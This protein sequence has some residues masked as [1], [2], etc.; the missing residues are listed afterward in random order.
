MKLAYCRF[1]IFFKSELVFKGGNKMK[2]ILKLSLFLLVLSF[3]LVACGTKDITA[4]KASTKATAAIPDIYP[5]TAGQNINVG[6]M[7]IWNDHDN[8]YVQFNLTGGWTMDESHVQVDNDL[9]GP[10][11]HADGAPIPGQ[12]DFQ[13]TYSPMVTTD[14]YTISRSLY[15]FDD[16]V[17]VNNEWV[18]PIVII[19]AHAS[20]RNGDQQETAFGGDIPGLSNRWWFYLNYQIT[21]ETPPPPPPHVYQYETAMMRMNDVANDF[22][23]RWIMGNGKPHAWFSYVKWTPTLTPHTFYFYAGQSYKCGEVQIWK[24]A[25]FL[26]VSIDMMNDWYIS[27]SHLNVKLTG[28]VGSPAFGL[29]PY[30]MTYD[31]VTDAYTYSVPWNTAWDGQ[32]LN[33]ALHAD[34]QKEI[35]QP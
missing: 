23:Y 15:S 1:S 11:I 30:P 19:V 35:V 8:I 13:R 12:F 16:C 28:Y 34:V 33:I 18:C 3:V 7:A 32:L 27:G 14:T 20:V 17:L 26:K 10:W 21:C 9:V 25:G 31:P 22:T 6:N 24:E 2:T 5:L 29:F 4:P